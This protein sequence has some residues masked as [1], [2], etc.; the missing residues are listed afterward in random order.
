VLA[1][2][3]VLATACTAVID[4]TQVPEQQSIGSGSSSGASG[5]GTTTTQAL[6]CDATPKPGRSPLRR[7]N[8]QE[9][10]TT[11]ADLLGVNTDVV[12]SF[13]PDEASLGFTNNA[14]V[15]VVTGLLAEAYMTAATSLAT[16]AV[17]NL[18]TLLPCDP[19][20]AGE[21]ACAKQFITSFGLRAFRR[22]LTDTE[23][24]TMFGVYTAGKAGGAFA[25]GIE[26]AI[27][28]FVQSPRFLYR[29]E[30][31][32]P[33]ANNTAV[34]SVDPYEMASRLSYFLWGTM[35]DA[36]LFAAAAADKLSQPADI[37]TQV[38]RMLQAPKA[39]SA[40][41]QF[42]NEWLGISELS[43]VVKD[44]TL[45]PQ[46]NDTIR[47]EVQQE[48]S[49]FVDD[50]FWNDGKL[51]TLFTAPYSFLNKD[52]A[53]YYGVTGPT[54]SNYVRTNFPA[55]QRAGILTQ[56]AILSVLAKPNQT[57]PVLRGKFVREMILCQ[58]LQPPPANLVITPPEVKPDATTRERFTEHSKNALC[59]GCHQL[60]DPVGFGFENYDAIGNYRTTDQTFPVDAS[61]ELIQTDVDGKFNGAVELANK[62]AQSPE[63]RQCMVKQWFRYATGRA[64]TDADACTLDALDKDFDAVNHDLR[65]LR[66]KITTSDAFRYRAVDGGGS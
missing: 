53:A 15:L 35:P 59:A 44:P 24:A 65:E 4:G 31:G 48:A 58:Q 12:N 56:G 54:D 27:E 29:V 16:E 40:V 30:T 5:P 7:L 14:D 36:D 18:T 37:E 1:P 23:Q 43:G 66:V 41:A 10:K 8:R 62:L 17:A 13:P 49:T 46:W 19:T 60:M 21:D 42:H 9:Y 61:G 26:L 45:Y 57:A 47:A 28:A 3:L 51:E 25:D 50:T 64:E 2:A 32:N 6:H 34:A 33:I 39:R 55:G 11:V 38:R 20:T 52:L 22:P 63:V